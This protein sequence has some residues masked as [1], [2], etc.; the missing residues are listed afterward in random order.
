MQLFNLLT[1]VSVY[2]PSLPRPEMAK[3]I[4]CVVSADCCV[5]LA[6]CC[7][8]L[9]LVLQATRLSRATEAIAIG[10]RP[11]LVLAVA[12]RPTSL[13]LRRPGRVRP[14]LSVA[15]VRRIGAPGAWVRR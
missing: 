14:A 7:V 8:V 4:V 12:R 1:C 13:A 2:W 9:V 10:T 6:E 5:M 15:T 3:V 11:V